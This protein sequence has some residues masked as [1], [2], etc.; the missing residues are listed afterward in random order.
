MGFNNIEA[1]TKTFKAL[2][3]S[4]YSFLR[5]FSISIF[6]LFPFLFV[7]L[8]LYSYPFPVIFMFSFSISLFVSISCY[9]HVLFFSFFILIHFL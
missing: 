1:F 8:F 3:F 9:F 6:F 5:K 4:N 2:N 7:F